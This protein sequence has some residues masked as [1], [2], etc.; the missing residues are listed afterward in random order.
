MN[1][2]IKETFAC[3]SHQ[4]KIL[5]TYSDIA[6]VLESLKV[7]NCK[8]ISSI[9]ERAKSKNKSLNEWAIAE[10]LEAYELATQESQPDLI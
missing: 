8:A 6:F 2:E 3:L 7:E 4:A 1:K 5:I 10:I 9:L